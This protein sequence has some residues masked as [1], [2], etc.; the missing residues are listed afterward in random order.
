MMNNTRLLVFSI[1]LLE[2]NPEWIGFI[3]GK[4]KL[5]ERAET[6]SERALLLHVRVDGSSMLKRSRQV[7]AQ[8][9]CCTLASIAEI[10]ALTQSSNECE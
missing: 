4:A 2:Y 5:R 9:W 8:C 3:E 7:A 10:D 1:T 6:T